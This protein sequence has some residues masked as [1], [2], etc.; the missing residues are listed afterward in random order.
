MT[1]KTMFYVN[2]F[3][4]RLHSN[5]LQLRKPVNEDLKDT[6]LVLLKQ[7]AFKT[8]SHVLR[9]Q[10]H[11]FVLLNTLYMEQW[12]QRYEDEC[13]NIEGCPTITAWIL[14]VVQKAIAT[15]KR[16][17]HMEVDIAIG[18][19]SKAYFYSMCQSYGR[20]FWV[21][22]RGL[23]KKTTLNFGISTIYDMN[24]KEVEIFGYV[25]AIIRVYFD[26]MESMLFKRRFWDS[27]MQ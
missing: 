21:M 14:P 3:A 7:G 1:A 11:Q 19:T 10:C 5:A 24:G 2:D 25:E 15:Q 23:N 8:L 20:H 9:E 22:S 13:G 27:V 17:D 18:P 12:H 6:G 4:L 16:V 26:S